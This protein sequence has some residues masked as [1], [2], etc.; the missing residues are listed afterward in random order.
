M[1]T[2]VSPNLFLPWTSVAEDD[3]RLHRLLI[4]GVVAFV[5]FVVAVRTITL[6]PIPKVITPPAQIMIVALPVV[7]PEPPVVEAPPPEPEPEIKPETK[8]EIKPE[9][10]PEPKPELKKPDPIKPDPKTPPVKEPLVKTPPVNEAAVQ[11]TRINN[12]RNQAAN[13]GVMQAQNELA[14][15][16]DSLSLDDVAKPTA[17]TLNS[18]ST[19]AATVDRAVISSGAT[20]KSGGINTASLS[21]NTG[22]GGA[23]G[24]RKGTNVQSKLA[25]AQQIATNN[26][27]AAAASPGGKGNRTD[28]EVK[29][30]LDA[31]KARITAAYYRILDED[32]TLQGRM[33]FKLIIEASGAVS[34]VKL[35]S[36]DIKN[37][38]LEKKISAL[39]RGLN[40]GA[41]DVQ[42]Y[43]QNIPIDLFPS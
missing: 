8:P 39:L 42:T 1:A 2:L 6:P 25:E 27:Q 38:D 24:G 35:V 5:L 30:V 17:S 7:L 11:A 29:K 20:T 26:R 43:A 36:S 3:R 21:T 12:A 13:A 16:R 14:A 10:Q 32:P 18:A 15:M 37:V 22:A 33:V 19:T 23:L 9:P 34:D 28:E 31:A 41:K 40:F 4:A